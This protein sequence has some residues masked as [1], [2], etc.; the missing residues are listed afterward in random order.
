MNELQL[1]QI[2]GW[3]FLFVCF[4]AVLRGFVAWWEK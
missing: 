3:L 1:A 4:L 2:A